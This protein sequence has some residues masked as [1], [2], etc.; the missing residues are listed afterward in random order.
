MWTFPALEPLPPFGPPG[1]RSSGVVAQ[2]GGA[3]P[4]PFIS[5]IGGLFPFALWGLTFRPELQIERLDEAIV[6][7]LYR[8]TRDDDASLREKLRELAN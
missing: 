7:G 3:A 5:V 2:G 6:C 1:W 8:S 4:D